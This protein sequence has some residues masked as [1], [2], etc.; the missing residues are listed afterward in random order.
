MISRLF[1]EITGWLTLR[2][3]ALFGMILIAGIAIRAYNITEPPF[4]LDELFSM[5]GSAPNQ[6]IAEV[7]EYSKGDQP[8]VFF[9]ILYQ[10]LKIFG[11]TELAARGLVGLFGVIGIV[12]IYYLGREVKNDRLG[13][14]V[15]FL[16]A[17]NHFHISI[18]RE[19]RFYPLV[20]ALSSLSFLFMIRFIKKEKIADLIWYIVFTGLL[21]NTHYYGLVVLVAQALIFLFVIFVAG[22][23]TRFI[24]LGLL[25]GAA[26]GMTLYHW[27]PIILKDLQ[28]PEFHVAAVDVLFP[29]RFLWIY[30]K[31]A[32]ALIVCFISLVFFLKHIWGAVKSRNISLE[33][34]IL[35]GWIFFGFFIPLLYSWIRMPMLTPKY[36]TITL[37]ALFLIIGI[38]FLEVKKHIQPYL[39]ALML[40]SAILTLSVIKPVDRRKVPEDWDVVA[41]HFSEN[42]QNQPTI[43][44]QLAYF[45]NFY[46][47]TF[48]YEGPLPIDQRFCD[49][50]GLVNRAEE[51]WLLEHD[52]Y[53]DEGFTVEQK[54]LIDSLFVK[55]DSIRFR[56]TKALHFMRKATR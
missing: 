54:Q 17:I 11:T 41:K 55:T 1:S 36:A 34:G 44:A 45:H 22:K 4:W 29:F 13:F 25:G 26:S 14:F 15:A 20:F 50:T 31:D 35:F 43:F 16:T 33:Y 32:G 49:F 18:S 6:T 3:R 9:F 7:Y 19:V 24:A 27:L 51:I 53:P 56:E 42:V 37:P 21:L 12:A 52:R 39:I 2:P 28:T 48:G 8:P 30:F 5:N 47:T 23:K 38:G 46:F 10:W 40:A